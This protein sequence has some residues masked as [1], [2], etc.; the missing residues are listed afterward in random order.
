MSALC[1]V[2]QK[3]PG[4]HSVMAAG[5]ETWACEHCSGAPHVCPSCNRDCY[6]DGGDTLNCEHDCLEDFDD[7]DDDE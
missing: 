2:C 3:R 5:V 6:C 7:Q 4:T 1:D